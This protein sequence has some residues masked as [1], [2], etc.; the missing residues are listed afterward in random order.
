MVDIEVFGGII[1]DVDLKLRDVV[2]G[3]CGNE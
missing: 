3:F 2:F 1:V